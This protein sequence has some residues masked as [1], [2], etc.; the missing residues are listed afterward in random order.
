M[1]CIHSYMA[2]F[3]VF[4][5][6][7]KKSSNNLESLQCGSL[8]LSHIQILCFAIANIPSFYYLIS[9]TSRRLNISSI[10]SDDL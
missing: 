2:M 10:L 8:N 6:Y 9:Y 5:G 4:R 7:I 3:Y 1:V